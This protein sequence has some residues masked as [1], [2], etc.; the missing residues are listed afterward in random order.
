MATKRER[1][2]DS[3]GSSV[4][5]SGTQGYIAVPAELKE[6]VLSEGY[7]TS[8]RK[9]VP[10]TLVDDAALAAKAMLHHN[11]GKETVVLEVFGLREEQIDR[12]KSKVRLSRLPSENLSDG[13]VC[14]RQVSAPI[15][16]CPFCGTLLPGL[17]GPRVG[18][19]RFSGEGFFMCT[20][21]EGAGCREVQQQRHER[22]R[23]SNARIL[24]HQT[25]RSTADLIKEK[26][27]LIRGGGGAA[28]AGVYFADSVMATEWKAEHHG[29]V[30]KCEV[31]LG[32]SHHV[33]QH[34]KKD[35]PLTF[36]KLADLSCDSVVIDRGF[37]P[38]GRPH[39]GEPSGSEYVVY[40]WDQVKILGEVPRQRRTCSC[41]VHKRDKP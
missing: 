22:L 17:A 18:E 24:Y 9:E 25:S 36:A 28:G 20:P 21:C 41:C 34:D 14:D 39:A 33:V 31:Q 32:Q 35:V 3:L 8:K 5:Y 26:G 40:S 2:V 37:V 10:I 15:P 7:V 19:H 1:S 23:A 38:A 12:Q 16:E 30:L 13:S 11:P 6:K 4:S 27:K 29:V